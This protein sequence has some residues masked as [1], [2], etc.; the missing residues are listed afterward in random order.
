MSPIRSYFKALIN[1]FTDVLIPHRQ[2][3]PVVPGIVKLQTTS[4]HL[5]PRPPNYPKPKSNGYYSRVQKY[6]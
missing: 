6:P 4:R 2:L 1:I 5:L 3:L